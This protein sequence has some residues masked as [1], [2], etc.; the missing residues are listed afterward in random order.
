[1]RKAP[2]KAAQQGGRR[3]METSCGEGVRPG[4]SG[5]PSHFVGNPSHHA[6]D[7][8][9]ASLAGMSSLVIYNDTL[10]KQFCC[11]KPQPGRHI[12][13]NPMFGTDCLFF[14][15]ISV[16]NSSGIQKR[17]YKYPGASHS[18]SMTIRTLHSKLPSTTGR[19]F[20]KIALCLGGLAG[21]SAALRAQ[22]D[23]ATPYTFALLAGAGVSGTSD[24]TGNA[25]HFDNPYGVALDSSGNLFVA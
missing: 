2:L 24:G 23:Y 25:A 1:M 14:F 9:P 7:S 13:V 10:Q 20:L 15:S 3:G 12:C 4:D 18:R 22:S 17:P 5:P 19:S 16:V 8:C 21:S 11:R 6:A